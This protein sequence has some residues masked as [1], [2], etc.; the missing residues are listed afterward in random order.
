M[1][2]LFVIGLCL[3]EKQVVDDYRKYC[4]SKQMPLF[5]DE[6][7]HMLL[8]FRYGSDWFMQEQSITLDNAPSN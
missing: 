4:D 7:C 2:Y 6:Y 3:W 8:Q 5:D 1:A